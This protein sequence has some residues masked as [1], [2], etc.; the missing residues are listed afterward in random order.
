MQLMIFICALLMHFF[1]EFLAQGDLK[2]Y[3]KKSYWKEKY[4][5][6]FRKDDHKMALGI[7]SL[8]WSICVLLPAFMYIWFLLDA[9]TNQKACAT[10]I[11]YSILP[12]STIVHG[13]IDDR[14]CNK[15]KISFWVEQ[16]LY[17]L[18]VIAMHVASLGLIQ[19]FLS[20]S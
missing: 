19:L 3:K 9:D 4:Q 7:H 11:L 12:A 13:W 10:A 14:E 16:N 5:E 17:F 18:E 1:A 8:M 2:E 15:N 20:L 6:D